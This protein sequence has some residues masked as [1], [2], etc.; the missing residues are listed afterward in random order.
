MPPNHNV[1]QKERNTLKRKRKESNIFTTENYQ[2][3][4]INNERNKGYTNY[5]KKKKKRDRIKSSYINNFAC[6]LSK[7]KGIDCLNE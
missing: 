6:K 3:T 1:K 5:K 2:A 7:L 4:L